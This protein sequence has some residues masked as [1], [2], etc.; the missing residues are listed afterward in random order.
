MMK[1][2][3]KRMNNPVDFREIHQILKDIDQALIESKL[4]EI[5]DVSIII[6]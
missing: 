1:M 4:I 6:I 2:K 3:M 5:A